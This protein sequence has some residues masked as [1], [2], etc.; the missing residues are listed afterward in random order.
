[1]TPPTSAA[2]T[3]RPADF[4]RLFEPLAIN[5]CSIRNR[6]VLT[7]HG[8]GMPTDGTPNDQMVAYY[9]E[10]AKGEVGL[11]ML[12]TQQ[13]HP[14]SPG[15]TGLLC[16]YDDRI[17]PGLKRVADAVH[18]H[19]AKIFGYL[20]HMGV[21]TSA[22]PV[23]LWSASPVY[24]HKYGEVAHAMTK[25]E[26]DLIIGAFKAAAKRNVEAGMDGIEIHCG[27]GLL[28]MQFLSPLTNL[29]ED[30][31]GG[32]VE[33]RTRLP[34]EV[35]AAVREAVGPDVP[36]GV[37]IS[38][39]ELVPGGLT[40]DDM[41]EIC[42]M[43]VEAGALDYIDVSA[44]SDGDYVS[45]MLHEPPMGLPPAPY[46][47]M[48]GRIRRACPGVAILHATRI[49]TAAEAEAL[50]SR[51]DADMAGMVRPLI[52]DP[53]LPAKAR[54][55]EA[56]R[57]TPCVACEQACFGRL[58]R[59]RHISCVGNPTTGREQAWYALPSPART[60]RL[61][62]VGAGPAGMEAARVAALRGH[63]VVLFDDRNELG[64]RMNTAKRPAG[65]A[66]WGRMIAH[67]AAEIE[68][69]GVTLKLGRMADAEAILA[70]KPDAVFLACGSEQKAI[71][72]P[73]AE[74]AP[75]V[76]VD[77]AVLDPDLCG[78]RILVIDNINRTPA[79]ATAVHLA[80]LGRRVDMST[81]GFYA[82]HNL[83]IQNLSFFWREAALH[84][85]TFLP[86]TRPI[87]FNKGEVTLEHVF[88]REPLP[89]RQ[90]DTIVWA[91]PGIPRD[92]LLAELE[93]RVGEVRAIGDAYAPRDIEAAFLDGYQA[94][95][96]L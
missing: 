18:R 36:L 12:G 73:G 88:S 53:Y 49:H 27:H 85:V 87:A 13:V 92:G 44:G 48:A 60:R 45:N 38:A 68:R 93:G 82:G 39:D 59:G 6:I 11:I 42:P 26:I 33:N 35:L 63:E 95:L 66:E 15:I 89:V 14:S 34:R 4:S 28:L 31:Y 19:G 79:M 65:R 5:G 64:G 22:R 78:E 41:E 9:E 51:G 55:G 20:G 67:K 72:L 25:A 90:Y 84:G 17:I 58:Y 23:P 21:A 54:R 81:Q 29:R 57:V 50:L 3:S 94:A 30:A 80:K 71:A 75:I 40:I 32:S 91:D 56:E 83:V 46:A 70:E 77:N 7:G 37:R 76:I 16:N 61:C 43:L 69:L 62:I 74:D 24:E 86:A 10:R 8:T 96:S 2:D 1:M 47:S 52:A